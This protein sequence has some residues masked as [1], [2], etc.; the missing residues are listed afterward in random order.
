MT[1]TTFRPFPDWVS[2][3]LF[4]FEGNGMTNLQT[5][6]GFL[7]LAIILVEH[8]AAFWKHFLPQPM[9]HRPSPLEPLFL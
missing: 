6:C 3:H 4:K 9:G 8:Q 7:Q 2:S 5:N 1:F